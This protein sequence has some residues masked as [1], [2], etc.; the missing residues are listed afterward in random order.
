MSAISNTCPSH[1][2]AAKQLPKQ[3]FKQYVTEGKTTLI[4][5]VIFEQ[6]DG[7]S[8]CTVEFK[9]TSDVW[10]W[11]VVNEKWQGWVNVEKDVALQDRLTSENA[12]DD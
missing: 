2:F 1:T 4:D 8:T 11:K 5:A 12:F 6:P 7:I 9:S 10:E 3:I